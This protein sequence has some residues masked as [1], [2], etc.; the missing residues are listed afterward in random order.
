MIKL[1]Q[2]EI[3]I[4][5]AFESGQV[6]RSM[7]AEEIQDRHQQYAKSLFHKNARIH[8]RLSSNIEAIVI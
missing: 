7:N 5:N 3:E 2:E 4:L 6:K 8:I 1:D